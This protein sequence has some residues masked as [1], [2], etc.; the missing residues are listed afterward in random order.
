MINTHEE[1]REYFS[2]NPKAKVVGFA[3]LTAEQ[4]KEH[5]ANQEITVGEID[6]LEVVINPDV[7]DI[8]AAEYNDKVY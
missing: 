3:L 4:M 5:R 7:K 2:E 6:I 1:S 8:I